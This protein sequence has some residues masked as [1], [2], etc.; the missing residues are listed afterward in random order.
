M[1][2]RALFFRHASFARPLISR[3]KVTNAQIGGWGCVRP[4][5][6]GRDAL[7]GRERGQ[8]LFFVAG[9]RLHYRSMQALLRGRRARREIRI[10]RD[11]P[12]GPFDRLVILLKRK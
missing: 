3:L 6:V 2:S 10:D 8:T 11:R 5:F 1:R 7:E 4:A 9:L 12:A